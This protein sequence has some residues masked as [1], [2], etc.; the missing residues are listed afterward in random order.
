MSAIDY[1]RD[2]LA[3]DVWD[4]TEDKVSLKT[5]IKNQVMDYVYSFLDD[6]DIP[7]EREGES[8]PCHR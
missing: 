7:E 4:V 8:H 3:K 5:E 2:K 6:M 1:V